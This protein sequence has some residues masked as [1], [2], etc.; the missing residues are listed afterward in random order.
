MD[1]DSLTKLA[2]LAAFVLTGAHFV[3]LTFF[4]LTFGAKKIA[5]ELRFSQI[6]SKIAKLEAEGR[7]E[8]LKN[9][10]FQ[11]KYKT[12]LEGFIGAM[13]NRLEDLNKS[14]SARFI[15][16]FSGFDT[17]KELI[18]TKMDLAISKNNEKK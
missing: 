17:F 8:S 15:D 13:D 16:L 3:I 1:L 6:E 2:G 12:T 4:K 10:S 14:M 9:N 7:A 18:E 11:H 5:D